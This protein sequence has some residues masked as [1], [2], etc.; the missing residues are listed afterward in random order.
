MTL[1]NESAE[2]VQVGTGTAHGRILI[3]DGTRMFWTP[4]RGE[5]E[6]QVIDSQEVAAG[7]SY[8]ITGEWNQISC[9]GDGTAGPPAPP[10]DYFVAGY[11]QGGP[12]TWPVR[13]ADQATFRIE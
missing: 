9:S 8:R 12:D 13:Y 7:E 4:S 6:L 11:F 10:G 2:P 5:F 1:V 3:H